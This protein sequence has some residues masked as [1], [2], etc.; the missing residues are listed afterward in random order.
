MILI[1]LGPATAGNLPAGAA[2]GDHVVASGPVATVGNYPVLFAERVSMAHATPIKVARP[3]GN[4]PG[5]SR[6]DMEASQILDSGDTRNQETCR[7]PDNPKRITRAA[8]RTTLPAA[9]R[10]GPTSRPMFHS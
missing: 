3:D 6:K 5:A 2:A 4:Y 8:G 9:R 7:S 10:R 1:D